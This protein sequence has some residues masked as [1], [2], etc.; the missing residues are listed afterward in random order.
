MIRAGRTPRPLARER[1]CLCKYNSVFSFTEWG[2]ED[3]GE[4]E[5]CNA[6]KPIGVEGEIRKSNYCRF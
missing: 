2:G 6:G 5:D 3:A 1:P 4:E